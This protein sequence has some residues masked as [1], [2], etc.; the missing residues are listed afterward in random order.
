MRCDCEVNDARMLM[1]QHQ[2]DVQDLKAN[3]GHGQEFRHNPG[4][5]N[6]KQAIRVVQFETFVR[7]ALKNSNLML[8]RNVLQL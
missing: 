3:R 8:R 6:P 4:E 1:R 2:E 5:P 7:G